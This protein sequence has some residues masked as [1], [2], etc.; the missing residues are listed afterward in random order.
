MTKLE[1]FAQEKMNEL[2]A[3]KE[4]LKVEKE[5][6]AAAKESLAAH[7]EAQKVIQ[8][9]ASGVQTSVHKK[10]AS[11]VTRC[12]QTV[13]NE[14]YQFKIYFEQ[15]R[16]KTE[17]RMVF[18]D[19]NGHD[20]DPMTESGGGAVELAAFALRLVA[21]LMTKPQPRK[22]LIL[23]EPFRCVS[24]NH[25]DRLRELIESLSKELEMQFIIVTH[26][27]RLQ[28]GKIIEVE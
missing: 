12:L 3:A 15:K 14:Q 28:F 7:Q 21:L 23:D 8:G 6:L 26:D 22:V 2:R 1:R 11:V 4:M 16:G 13:L 17:A 27:E 24:R 5:N 18:V 10:I 19:Q 9:V 25:A 20:I